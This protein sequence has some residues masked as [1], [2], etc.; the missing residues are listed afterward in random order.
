M[1]QIDLLTTYVTCGAASCAAALMT[2]LARA[3]EPEL[4][5]VLRTSSIGFA[6]LGV[7]LLQLVQGVDGPMAASMLLALAGSTVGIGGIGGIGWGLAQLAG[8]R[9]RGRTVVIGVGAAL[10]A[11][12][13]ALPLSA[14]ALGAAYSAGITLMCAATTWALRDFIRRPRDVTEALIG[15]VMVGF[16]LAYALRTALALA[17]DGPPAAAHAYGPPGVLRL[18]GLLYGVMPVVMATLLL[19]VVNGR[20]A[21]QL[22]LRAM[23]DELTGALNRRALH[24]RAPALQA[25]AGAAGETLALLVTDL[26]HF[27]HIND[28]HGHAAGDEVLRQVVA[29]L[30][31]QLRRD[32]LLTR[33]GGEE[34]VL[35][36]PVQDAAAAQRVAERLR[37]AVGRQPVQ[38]AGQA[39]RVTASIGITLLAPDEPLD[40]ALAR[41]DAA[42]YRAKTGG[43]DRVESDL[44]Q[45]VSGADGAD[46]AADGAGAGSV[47]TPAD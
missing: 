12:A 21:A 5:R 40:A 18:L 35:L 19:N 46:R 28:S 26:D 23:T 14:M 25:Q 17:H 33:V 11:Q 31:A 15:A 6:L 27:K 2:M 8:R 24:A 44:P 41:A 16:V 39:L 4:A 3:G 20:L 13:A 43:R 22:A 10:A 34:F 1:L 42:L 47:T 9:V 7:S 29:L 30:R 38:V 32:A 37:A 36:V 45:A